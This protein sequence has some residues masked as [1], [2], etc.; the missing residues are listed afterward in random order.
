MSHVASVECEVRD[1][2][3]LK[4]AAE[5]L[6]F[7][8][9][10]GQTTHRWY[11]KWLDD[12]RSPRAASNKGVDP[13]TFG[14]CDHALRMRTNPGGYEIGVTEQ[15][16]GSYRLVYD[17]FGN[18]KAIEDLAGVDLLGLRNEIAA[19]TAT[20]VLK[21]RGWMVKREQEKNVIRLVATR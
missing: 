19:E 12:W 13:K 18:G 15:A 2:D 21:R 4:T 7:E 16:D 11:G 17:S 20:N 8:F 6:G 3:A 1:L 9:R 10:E 5:A 14:K